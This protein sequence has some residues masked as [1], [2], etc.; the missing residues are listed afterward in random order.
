M[1]IPKSKKNYDFI[2]F[3]EA[4][5]FKEKINS[6]LNIIN[7][8]DN[9]L[10]LPIIDNKICFSD[11]IQF[12]NN[13]NKN[14]L[15][16]F[17]PKEDKELRNKICSKDKHN[18]LKIK[19]L[20]LHKEN[21]SRNNIFLLLKK[22]K[23]KDINDKYQLDSI[24]DDFFNNDSL[25]KN[26]LILLN[27]Y[28]YGFKE[29]KKINN[30]IKK[31]GNYSQTPKKLKTILINGS[32]LPYNT[33]NSNTNPR[34]IRDK[35]YGKN[36]LNYIKTENNKKEEIR[37]KL[38]IHNIF[39]EW[40]LHT[41]NN[42]DNNHLNLILNKN[43]D[44][45]H[46]YDSSSYSLNNLN[47][48]I[49]T[50]KMHNNIKKTKS[51]DILINNKIRNKFIIEDDSDSEFKNKLINALIDRVKFINK[52]NIDFNNLNSD[53]FINLL[54][55]LIRNLSS[56]RKYINKTNNVNKKDEND[57]DYD[58]IIID[59]N[60]KK[61]L[62]E[63]SNNFLGKFIQKF[64]QKSLKT[65]ENDNIKNNE[66][67]KTIENKEDTIDNSLF[68]KRYLDNKKIVEKEKQNEN[69]CN[70]Y[71]S[72][73]SVKIERKLNISNLNEKINFKG[74]NEEKTKSK[75]NILE[76]KKRKSNKIPRTLEKNSYK[77]K[78]SF[79]NIKNYYNVV[80]ISSPQNIIKEKKTINEPL[81]LHRKETKIQKQNEFISN[82]NSNNY[83]KLNKS[84]NSNIK[85][86]I[87]NQINEKN[88]CDYS[89]ENNNFNKSDNYYKNKYIFSAKLN[90]NISIQIKERTIISDSVD[91][92][93][94]FTKSE[95]NKSN[96]TN[97]KLN[98]KITVNIK[99]DQNSKKIN[100]AK[101]YNNKDISETINLKIPK[102][103]LKN[104]G[105]YDIKNKKLFIRNK[106]I[107]YINIKTDNN[108][109][110]NQEKN[111][112]ENNS[113][114][115]INNIKNDSEAFNSSN[116]DEND[117]SNSENENKDKKIDV[118]INDLNNIKYSPI[119]KENKENYYI[120]TEKFNPRKAKRYTTSNISNS[121][122]NREI[123]QS[124]NRR[125]S[126]IISPSFKISKKRS[127]INKDM[128]II[129][130]INNVEGGKKKN[131]DFLL[132]LNQDNNT[133]FDE[134]GESEKNDTIDEDFD[135]L[136]ND[137][138][139][140]LPFESI[141]KDSELDKL[142]F[143]K[144]SKRR[145]KRR[146]TKQKL[147]KENEEDENS[148]ESDLEFIKIIKKR[149]KNRR[150]RSS[151][152]N[153]LNN[154]ELEFY[155]NN[156]QFNIVN[157][158]GLNEEDIKK[159]I[160][161]SIELRKIA[162]LD[163]ESK[164]EEIIKIEK[165]MKQKYNEILSKYLINQQVRGL[166]KKKKTLRRKRFNILN[167]EKD[168]EDEIEIEYKLKE[169]EEKKKE[170]VHVR[171]KIEDSEEELN[172]KETNEEVNDIP[173][174]KIDKRQLIYDN[175]YL[176]NKDKKENNIAI[177]KEVL[178]ILQNKNKSNDNNK[179]I[180]K[181]KNDNIDSKSPRKKYYDINEIL[182]SRRNSKVGKKIIRK[183]RGNKKPI[184]K[185][186]LSLFT[187]IKEEKID[188][189]DKNEP[190]EN[191]KE[192]LLDKKLKLFFEEIQRIKKSGGNID[193]SNLLKIE[194][195][196]DK[197]NMNR[198]TDFTE[199]ISSFRIKEKN[200]KSKFNFLSPIKFKTKHL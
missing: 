100:N 80:L 167:E 27:K 117:S 178:D 62:L 97:S 137:A 31:V 124:H 99:N 192:K 17:K 126:Y 123:K 67:L 46:S 150:R 71:N 183:L 156:N 146:T 58:E 94:K 103:N 140:Y 83:N 87:K 55:I 122:K 173:I 53:S 196:K 34:N 118:S 135:E 144:G 43:I 51:A 109:N 72:N 40:V 49:K 199:N 148:D 15:K 8:N 91:D 166:I 19:F 139:T 6:Q 160:K 127:S 106:N 152:M 155:K 60:N 138:L 69:I 182:N 57:I 177:K 26:N 5:G 107:K 21:K 136:E 39:F 68:I 114:E 66:I 190:E 180:I 25:N 181:S 169:K 145:T 70:N 18:K 89:S 7:S 116:D 23:I 74:Y 85:S 37:N 2:A 113:E 28:Y 11:R 162:E 128:K 119:K 176:F 24:N 35:I 82:Y 63:K 42:L 86:I 78:K 121:K 32:N 153:F 170:K 159:L 38:I 186:K 61:L 16:G 132:S 41:I 88:I 110:Y 59:R 14:S 142:L 45:N 12:S 187:D 195:I 44:A 52:D 48:K 125:G 56:R 105:N 161:Y 172:E 151:F 65:H 112:E 93:P 158:K 20:S 92:S 81:H 154:D 104:V 175:S 54:N 194:E 120:N 147:T 149:E 191:V 84:L 98:K 189:I 129:N 130:N 131:N 4:Q 133:V 64:I 193:F 174:K 157:N 111:K 36:I 77:A 163:N 95:R 1:K 108:F 75:N 13:N 50:H 179:N 76:Y 165:E 115:I 164:T 197:E 9:K 96:V 22:I 168:E 134:N 184:D 29:D 188:K 10:S 30:N 102:V 143:N 73:K 141:K 171:M 200:Y 33:I 198:L 101:K 185:Y 79:D 3:K 90:N 47:K